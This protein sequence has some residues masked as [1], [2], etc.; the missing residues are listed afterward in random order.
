VK[1]LFAGL[2]ACPPIRNI[3]GAAC[4]QHNEAVF[5]RALASDVRNV[6]LASIWTPLF[7]KDPRKPGP[8]VE[9]CHQV[10]DDCEPFE[11]NEAALAFATDQLTADLKQLTAA[12]KHVFITTQV[13]LHSEDV[14]KYMAMR[15]WH[16]EPLEVALPT[17]AHRENSRA[18]DDAFRKIAGQTGAVLIDPAT[19]LCKESH[20]EYERNRL[21]LYLDNN[22]LTAQGARLLEP[23]LSQVLEINAPQAQGAP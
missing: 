12:G 4:A 5:K 8:E 21:A 13:P 14:A 20:C 9:L 16:N 19:V 22:H 1:G 7:R 15:F 2:D 3:A 11:S 6:V 10:D 17:E 23:M 18:V